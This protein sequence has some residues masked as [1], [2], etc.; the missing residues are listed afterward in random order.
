MGKPKKLTKK[1]RLELLEQKRAAKAYCDE[2]AKRNEFDYGNCW[3]YA[4]EFNST[5]FAERIL[6]DETLKRLFPASPQAQEFIDFVI[7]ALNKN[8]D[9]SADGL[10]LSGFKLGRPF[11]TYCDTKLDLI[12]TGHKVLF[13]LCHI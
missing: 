1:Q 11:D 3:D 10:I 13:K 6:P 8:G 5:K 7:D 2:L 12:E 9:F 4:C